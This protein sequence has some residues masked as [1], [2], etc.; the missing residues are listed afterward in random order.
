MATKIYAAHT[1]TTG[2]NII[3]AYYTSNCETM[4]VYMHAYMYVCMHVCIHV[5]FVC[6]F[7]MCDY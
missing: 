4:Y 3:I 1:T 5:Y 6:I 2:T 7:Y